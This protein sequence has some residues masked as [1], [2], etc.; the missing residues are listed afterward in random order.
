MKH[1]NATPLLALILGLSLVACSREEPVVQEPDVV[2]EAVDTESAQPPAPDLSASD[3]PAEMVEESSAEAVVEDSKQPILLAQT[4]PAVSKT[5]WKYKE[6]QHYVRMVPTQP[7]VGGADKIEVAEFFWYGCAHCFDF[8]PH[9][10]RWAESKPAGVRFVRIPA[11]WNP[12]VMLHAQLYYT[13]E[14]LAKNGKI[15]DPEAFRSAVFREYHQRGNRMTTEAAI[16]SVFASQGVSADDFMSTWKSFEVAQKLRVAQDLARRYAISGVP[17]IVV[18]GK[19]RTGAGEAG[20]YPKLLELIN[21]LV[22]RE[23]IR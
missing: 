1:T 19:Y 21:E 23:T 3:E 18:N 10:N 4:E 17:A 20:G 7:T 2:E 13:E 11:T 16:Q 9:I 22:E 5:D 14:V 6:G 15:A 12:L 8:E